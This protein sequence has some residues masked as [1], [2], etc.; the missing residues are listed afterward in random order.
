MAG[1]CTLA[2]MDNRTD[3]SK[4]DLPPN[5]AFVV[6][7]TGDLASGD[8]LQGRAEHLASGR[9]VH[10]ESLTHLSEFVERVFTQPAR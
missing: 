9:V 3:A 6:Q 1:A 7:F 8:V 2:P 5:R 10:F 4:V